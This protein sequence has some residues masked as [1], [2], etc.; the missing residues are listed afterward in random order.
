VSVFL[1]VDCFRATPRFSALRARE[2]FIR[3]KYESRT[4]RGAPTA[5]STIK[6]NQ[7]L[8]VPLTAEHTSAAL[9]ISTPAEGD[10]GQTS[11]S[12][13]PAVARRLA[14]LG[15]T[16]TG[17]SSPTTDAN[18]AAPSPSGVASQGGAGGFDFLSP[19]A[20]TPPAAAAAASGFSFVTSA[21]TVPQG[22][23][24][25]AGGFS[26]GGG[27]APPSPL[28]KSVSAPQAPP[29]GSSDGLDDL[30]GSGSS[31]GAVAALPSTAPAT[32]S[33]KEDIHSTR[34]RSAS[35]DLL[36]G[37]MGGS[38]S[39][40]P[41]PGSRTAQPNA[42]MVQLIVQAVR[43]SAAVPEGT[44]AVQ[45]RAAMAAAASILAT[46]SSSIASGNEAAEGTF[47]S[48][49]PAPAVVGFSFS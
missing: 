5:A 25:A 28:G 26:F 8:G 31:D 21:S 4:W 29:A 41:V 32:A 11:P 2:S 1:L 33:L 17:S 6:A 43:G 36:G 37:F 20:G 18:S 27:V 42:D 46:Q 47:P 34:R 35:G 9:S 24:A 30:F 7:R 45:I 23:Q 44:P 19:S 13:N 12:L 48:S 22:Q 3:S 49:A 39:P 10:S 38:T 15:R 40:L 14:R 16:P